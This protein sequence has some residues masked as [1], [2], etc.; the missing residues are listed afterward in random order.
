M[1]IPMPEG[2]ETKNKITDFFLNVGKIEGYSYLI[3][4]GIAMPLKY[5]FGIPEWVRV[6]GLIH[7][8]L[9]I[10]FV[11]LLALMMG[12]VKLTPLKSFVCFL[13]SLIPFGTF[14]LKRWI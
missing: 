3:L 5:I 8:V 6:V 1:S 9:F 12:K 7:G 13:L 4:L 10:A 11:I 2:L 14:Y